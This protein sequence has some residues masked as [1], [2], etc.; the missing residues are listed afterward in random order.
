MIKH[1]DTIVEDN[2]DILYTA[3]MN[4][5]SDVLTNP[6]QGKGFRIDRSYLMNVPVDY[7]DEDKR[8][9]NHSVVLPS[10]YAVPL[11]HTD[12]SSCRS[13]M[14]TNQRTDKTTELVD[15]IDKTHD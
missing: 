7:N 3:T 13:V 1:E 5:W 14:G 6:K 11:M 8:K 2:E 4:M 10:S 15:D 12:L 9:Q